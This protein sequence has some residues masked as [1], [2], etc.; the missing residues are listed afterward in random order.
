ME[1]VNVASEFESIEDLLV[2]AS[3]YREDIDDKTDAWRT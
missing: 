2:Q 1:L 3:L